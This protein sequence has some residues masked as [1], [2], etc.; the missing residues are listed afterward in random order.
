[1]HKSIADHLLVRPQAKEPGTKHL[2]NRQQILH[3]LLVWRTR[4]AIDNGHLHAMPLAKGGK[5]LKPKARQPVLMGDDEA[6]HAPEFNVSQDAIECL[7]HYT[8][9][10]RQLLL[11]CHPFRAVSV[12][13]NGRR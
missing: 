9:L 1:L 12:S 11:A 5:S 13:A 4:I 7:T 8:D 2:D 10:T 6:L 3:Q